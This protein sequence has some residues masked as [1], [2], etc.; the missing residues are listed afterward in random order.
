MVNGDQLTILWHFDDIKSSHMDTK[1]QEEFVQ[2]I[3]DTYVSIDE[4]KVTRGKVHKYLGM[5]LDYSVQDQASMDMVDYVKSMVEGFPK[6]HLQGKVASPWNENL[7]KVQEK[8][9]KLDTAIAELFH[10]VT[11]QGLFACKRARP[12]ISPATAYLTTRVRAP[13]QDD[14]DKL[15]RMMKFLNQTAKD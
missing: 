14:W 5:K 11:A 10:T 9:P 12:N 13:N 6:E 8:S 7:F 4:V 2:W 3:R 15:V 1:V